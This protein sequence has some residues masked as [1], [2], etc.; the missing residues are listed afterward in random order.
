MQTIKLNSEVQY[1]K[2]VGPRRAA[3]LD[4]IN[5]HTVY[6]LLHFLPRRYLD[7]TM[8]TPIGTLKANMNATIIGKILGK[9]VLMGRTRRLEV[10]IGDESGYVA[11]IW[12]AGYRYLE[13]MF[14]KGDIYAATGP[15]TYFQQQQMVHPEI[16]RIEDADDQLIHTGRIVPV[17]PSTADLKSSGITGRTMR[18]I[19]NR[20]LEIDTNEIGDYL[21][22]KYRENYN[23]LPLDKALRSIHYPDSVDDA[24]RSRK[25][26][27]FD[28][29]LQLQYLIL[30]SRQKRTE[31]KKGHKY[32]KPAKTIEKFTRNLPFELTIDQDKV[33][34]TIFNDMKKTRPMHRLMQGDVG[35]GKTVVALL[36]AVY[37]SENKLQTGFMAPTELLAEQ[38]Y[39]NW[40][41]PL[42]KIGIEST[43]IIGSLSKSERRK[44]EEKIES[45]EI[46]IVFG[47]HA[48]L[49]DPTKFKKLGLVIIDE[50][51]R[52]GVK[53]RGQLIGKGQRPDILV[54]TATPIPRTLALT[55]YG[56]L[57]ISSIKSMPKG[58]Q[59]TKTVWR[60]A[61]ARADMYDFLKTRLADGDQIFIIYPL[62]EKSEK[63][64]LQAA[65]EEYKNLKSNIFKEYK[66][67]LV[68]GRVKKD[69]KEKTVL[70]FKTG[71]IQVLV[72]TT[73]I[74]VGI[75]IPS[76]SI[77]IIEH[78]ERFGLSQLHQLRGRVGR[79]EKRGLTIGVA[80]DPVSPLARKRLDMF[81]SSTD[82]FKIAE[83]DLELRG[84][85]EFFGTRQHGLPELKIADLSIDTDLLPY[86]REL[87]SEIL[88][89]KQDN[90][91]SVTELGKLRKYLEIRS[92]KRID[93][94]QFG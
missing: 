45:G 8:I 78:A 48:I 61:S 6:E 40:K 65:E 46:N 21:P 25:R 55:L 16:E 12:F 58:R 70:D 54:M 27:A 43:L 23:L 7:R 85:G 20:A 82:G 39:Q 18:Q 29:L 90:A 33:S 47:T 93:L 72:A 94:P 66:V 73:V 38:H 22:N 34:K 11:L 56:D 36:A 71:K 53:Q 50:Q 76:A 86:S 88:S 89:N 3:A 60:M 32:K 91:E 26:L 19:I 28:E 49:S 74:E 57:D 83:A 52:F 75:D 14:N 30:S 42:K 13:K 24:E 68:H 69:K 44:E 15:V 62:V 92:A 10:V 84:P 63:L 31:Q 5:I 9:G 2:G 35:C 4:G 41:E 79:G 67:G 87:I 37:A 1:L 81:V 17:Y 59:T 80:S 77:M 64:D 51:H